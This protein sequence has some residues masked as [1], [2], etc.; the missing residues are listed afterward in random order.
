MAYCGLVLLA[1]FFGFV[2]WGCFALCS[3]GFGYLGWLLCGLF[4]SD[5][6]VVSG[7]AV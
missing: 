4:G 2:V 6:W 3:A 7:Y 1:W 5:C